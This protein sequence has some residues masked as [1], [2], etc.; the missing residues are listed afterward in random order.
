MERL[1]QTLGNE[2]RV[3]IVLS[4]LTETASQAQLRERLGI[5]E[6][7]K[8]TL[9]KGIDA[10]LDVDLITLV[11][12]RYVLVDAD[13]TEQLLQHAADLH[14]SLAG[15][16]ANRTA[17]TAAEAKATAQDLRLGSFKRRSPRA[18]EP[19]SAVDDG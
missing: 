6:T 5:P 1:L 13:L 3:A 9:N 16:V 12:D 15:A 2:R 17:Q 7:Q 19:G 10:L 8:G 14:A 11:D 18:G 4:L